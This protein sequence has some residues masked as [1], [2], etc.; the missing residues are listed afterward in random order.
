MGNIAKVAIEA[1]E[2][3]ER[4][5]KYHEEDM[6]RIM[7]ETF[8]DIQGHILDIGCADALFLEAVG[9]AYPQVQLEGV[10]LSEELIERC[11][12]RF[13]G[14]DNAC[15]SIADAGNL[16]TDKTYQ[17]IIASGILTCFDDQLAILDHWLSLLENKGA[18]FCLA[19]LTPALSI[20]SFT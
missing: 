6:L 14:K 19:A 18:L 4:P 3:L 2:D 7:H 8:D 12:Q 20:A 13:S 1:Y 9:T 16:Q 17:A 11:H 5:L 10:D 15:F